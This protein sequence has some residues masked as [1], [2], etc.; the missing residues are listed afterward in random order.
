[1]LFKTT[2][3]PM[4]T[5]TLVMIAGFIPVGFAA[6]SAGEYCYSLFVVIGPGAAL[7][8]GRRGHLL[9]AHRLLAAVGQAHQGR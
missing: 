2:A 7:L 3:F 8:V 9:S 1:M 6:S 4:L 5:G